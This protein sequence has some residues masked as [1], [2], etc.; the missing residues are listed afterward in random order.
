MNIAVLATTISSPIYQLPINFTVVDG[1]TVASSTGASF[2]L[3]GVAAPELQSPACRQEIER[4]FEAKFRLEELL[5]SGVVKIYPVDAAIDR[6]PVQAKI[7]VDGRDVGEI[8]LSEGLVIRERNG[9]DWCS[10]RE[11]DS[12]SKSKMYTEQAGPKP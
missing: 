6:E 4:A 10:A 8:L 3:R 12:N 2:R 5:A 9:R 1:A 11:P 7:T